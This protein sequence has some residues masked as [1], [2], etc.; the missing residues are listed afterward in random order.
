[1]ILMGNFIPLLVPPASTDHSSIHVAGS[2]NEK[3][4]LPVQF[5]EKKRNSSI[6]DE[7]DGK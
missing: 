2:P 7:L 6:K 3:A 1:M 4:S 5:E